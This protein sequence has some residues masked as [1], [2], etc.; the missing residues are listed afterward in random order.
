MPLKKKQDRFGRI[1][2]ILQA[3]R[4]TSIKELSEKLGVS[5]MTIRRDLELLAGEGAVRLVHAGAI[6]IGADGAVQRYSLAEAEAERAGE[7]MRIGARA[8]SLVE[9]GDVVIVDSGS[10]TEWLVRSLPQ[11]VRLTVLCFALNV[12]VEARRF[13][14]IT[15]ILSGGTLRENSLVFD[16]PEG[17]A[18][19]RRHR[20][21]KA[22]LS[23][24][25]VSDRLGV[26][27][28]NSY[29]VEA[30]KAAIASSLTRILL[31]DSGKFGRIT[32]AWFADLKDFDRVVTDAG[33]A[34]EHADAVRR[35]GIELDMV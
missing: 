14:G 35:M 26:T 24:A 16:S 30:K 8:A 32:P 1:I 33:I 13:P 12:A 10:T 21:H 9:P 17:A 3:T 11:D 18:L 4:G 7:K 27:C 19:V 2:E 6:P 25:G 15:L 29:E 31:A 5:E 20:A 23:A 22:F 34:A 28:S